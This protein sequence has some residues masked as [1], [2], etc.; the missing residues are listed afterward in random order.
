MRKLFLLFVT[1]TLSVALAAAHDATPAG[2]DTVRLDELIV[3]G[4]MPGITLRTLPMTVSVIGNNKIEERKEPSLLPL[5]TEQVPGLFITQRGVMGYG[6]ANGAAGG[7]SIRGI[8]GAPTSG[9]LV[10]I[11]GHP[12][13][14]GLMGHPLADSYQSMMA[15]RVEVVRG[16]ASML[17]GSNAMGGV[18]NIITKK[19]SEE[20]FRNNARLMYGSFNSF[21]ADA[22]AGWKQQQF[23]G[24]AGI[25]Y[26]RSDGHRPDM[27]FEQLNGYA[28]MG[29][30]FS[31][32][33]NGSLDLNLSRTISSNPGKISNPILDNDA[34]ITRGVGSAVI[35]NNYANTSGAVK[36]FYN[37]GSHEIND[38]VPASA[39]YIPL[40]HRFRS[41]DFMAG[42]S[43]YQ[44]YA[45]FPGNRITA[46]FDH[47]RFGGKAWNRFPDESNNV[48]LADVRLH[49]SAGYLNLR[50]FL[51]DNRITLN[52]GLRLDHHQKNGSE[53]IPQLGLTYTPSSSTVLK[54]IMSKGFRNPTIREMY[55]FPPQN[56]DLQPE[57]LMSYELS[58]LQMIPYYRLRFGLNLFW[59]KG[60]NMIQQV[61]PGIGKWSNSGEVD[62][63]GV[64]TEISWQATTYLQLSANYSYLDMAYPIIAAPKHKLYAGGTFT[65]D[66]W[67]LSS[68]L[69]VVSGLHTTL[70]PTS[71]KEDFLL[72]NARAQYRLLEGIQLFL[73]GENLLDE[74]YEI[75]AGYPMPGRSLFGG[76]QFR[77]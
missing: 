10:L 76:L 65:Q 40:E 11:D 12:Q 7:M 67:S 57:R 45:F 29:Y 49:S 63:R 20:G 68:G 72:W 36:L 64:E 33:W 55:M 8:G 75:N 9:V 77:L 32:H 69:M 19:E 50:Q 53:W 47:F 46:G 26:N 42:V 51:F 37:F 14:M 70:N 44:S 43:L 25:G 52:A 18:I 15:E 5:L 2:V 1:L 62:N 22:A 71:P 23:Y 59:I 56:P 21:S 6:V 34:D 24:N 16:P 27:E 39:S 61:E 66:R 74:Q 73:K 28:R 48:T 17:Y 3:T 41:D 30:E 13:Y 4:S 60:D 54:A 58:L 31:S 38:G 35:E